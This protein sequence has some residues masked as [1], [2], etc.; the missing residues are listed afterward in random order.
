MPG[1]LSASALPRS[2][3]VDLDT[4]AKFSETT[5]AHLVE[6]LLPLT[7]ISGTG[8]PAAY[9]DDLAKELVATFGGVTSFLRAPAE[10]RW[11]DGGS[12]EHD[13]IVVIE[14]MT[15]TFDR[16]WWVAL[17]ARLEHL[18]SQDEVIIRA[19]DVEVL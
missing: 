1:S 6:I 10:G 13:D 12:T 3:G 17:K 11:H 8:F 5:M 4:M 18:F 16:A 19:H 14:V 2:S 9:Y 7:D 15:P